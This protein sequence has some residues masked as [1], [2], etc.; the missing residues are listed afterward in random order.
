MNYF[1]LMGRFLLLAY[2]IFLLLLAIGQGITQKGMF[3]C[4]PP[5]FI[6]IILI[7][8]GKH[9][10]WSALAILGLFIG[11]IVFFKTYQSIITFFIVSFPLL[12]AA[13]LLLIGS[14]L[15]DTV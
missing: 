2:S 7:S 11:T 4:I 14:K 6:I 13:A 12:A 8:L 1:S 10:V 9:P 3:Q 15:K 5:I